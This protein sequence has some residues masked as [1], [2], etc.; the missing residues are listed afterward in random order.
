MQ[1]RLLSANNLEQV[2]QT[3]YE[4]ALEF[5]PK[6][7]QQRPPPPGRIVSFKGKHI[8]MWATSRE[9][10]RIRKRKDRL[11]RLHTTFDKLRVEANKHCREIKKQ[12]KLSILEQAKAALQSQNSSGFLQ[13]YQYTGSKTTQKLWHRQRNWSA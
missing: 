4:V 12:K 1:D 9:L 6:F 2:Q 5:F 7:P 3:V 8:K 10:Q 13:A 11:W